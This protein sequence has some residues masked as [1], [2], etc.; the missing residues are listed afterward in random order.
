MSNLH[1]PLASHTMVTSQRAIAGEP[2]VLRAAGVVASSRPPRLTIL[3]AKKPGAPFLPVA[4][5]RLIHMLPWRLPK[6]I[7]SPVASARWTAETGDGELARQIDGAW[8]RGQG[9]PG[10]H[11]RRRKKAT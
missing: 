9:G 11:A 2:L 3:R 1:V 8:L 10:T 4:T 7:G 5:R 6:G